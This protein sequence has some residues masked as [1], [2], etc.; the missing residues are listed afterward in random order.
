MMLWS[1]EESRNRTQKQHSYNWPTAIPVWL[2]I[3]I[4]V[5]FIIKGLKE[6]REHEAGLLPQ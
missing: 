2:G 4:G 1:I 5:Y 6:I 3:A